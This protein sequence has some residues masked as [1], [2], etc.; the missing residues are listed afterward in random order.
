MKLIEYSN[1]SILLQDAIS[2]IDE[3]FVS[4]YLLFESTDRII[5]GKENLYYGCS[6]KNE[7]AI[8]IIYLHTEG[9]HYL[10]G[11]TNNINAVNLLANSLREEK[12]IGTILFGNTFIIDNLIKVKGLNVQKTRNRNY[13]SLIS[14]INNDTNILGELFIAK[15]QD[16]DLLAQLRLEFY[17]EEFEKKGVQTNE[18][19]LSEFKENLQS[20]DIYYYKIDNQITTLISITRLPE[21]RIYLPYIFTNQEFRG[22]GISKKACGILFQK[23]FSSGITEIGLNVKVSNINAIGLFSSL[24]M[25]KIYETAIYEC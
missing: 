22:K 7:N 21:N 20:G 9:A 18:K 14:A 25:K 13:M 8:E 23:L 3:N 6:I 5:H 2:V 17:N 19:I 15:E 1:P 11:K 16:Y 12:L 10:F 4:H 24:G